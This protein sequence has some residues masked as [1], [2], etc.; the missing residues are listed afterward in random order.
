MRET[1]RFLLPAVLCVLTLGCPEPLDGMPGQPATGEEHWLRMAL[2]TD[3][4]ILDEESPARVVRLDRYLSPA[5]RPQDGYTA[6]VLNATIQAIN[7]I[8]AE[9]RA[10]DCVVVT[11]DLIDNAQYNELRW[12]I[13]TM[14]GNTVD[15]DSGDPDGADRPVAPEDNPKLPLHA[16]G[17]DPAIPWFAAHGNHDGLAVGN[18]PIDRSRDDPARWRA[19][20]L[21][22]AS[23]LMGLYD[24]RPPVNAL[25]PTL[26]QSPAVIRADVEQI[27][28]ETLQLQIDE[29]VAGPIAPDPGRHFLSKRMFVEAF[30][31]STTLPNGHGF[32]RD[33]VDQ[34]TARYSV[35]PKPDV[36]IR[37]IVLDTVPDDL[38]AGLPVDYGVLTREQFEGFLM[39][40]VE[41]ARRAGECVIVVS[42]HPARSFNKPYPGDVVKTTPFR[43][44]LASQPHILAHVSGH[45][46]RHGLHL[47][48]G[49][50]RYVEIET[51]SLIDLPQEGQMLDF[52]HN[53][54]TN[55]L[56]I[57]GAFFGHANDPTRL[58]AESLRRATIDAAEYKDAPGLSVEE[59]FPPPKGWT[60][61]PP[62]GWGGQKIGST[63]GNG[64]SITLD[65]PPRKGAPK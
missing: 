29:L 45:E 21:A 24:M 60:S 51:G 4:H 32:T 42:H 6:H 46:H 14:D 55:E 33:N 58:S 49:L 15:T 54:E 59:V 28:P 2:L 37:M 43:A 3:V 7:R 27:D 1:M 18:F 31:D 41:A 64:F 53:P 26:D 30:F 48:T 11:G 47:V 39:P 35:R 23:R 16:V 9:D 62:D 56:R 22:P 44:Y 8:H 52:Y 19:L 25:W 50:H 34:G 63:A 20:M 38:P 36:P 57:E 10:V 40:E 5:W 65:V 13:D 17:L 12:F 61:A